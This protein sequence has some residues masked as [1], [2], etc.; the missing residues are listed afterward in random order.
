MRVAMSEVFI[1]H[2]IT[3]PSLTLNIDDLEKLKLI[4]EKTGSSPSFGIKTVAEELDFHDFNSFTKNNWPAN[5][6]EFTFRT[7]YTGRRIHG[8][9][10]TDNILGL[11]N[12]TIE[13]TDRDWISARV[14]ELKRFFDQHRN[15][16]NLFK[17]LNIV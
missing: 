17:I 6:N 3:I 5:I 4:L 15:W 1:T 14:D 16:H 11:S 2:K 9:I 12:V 7:N 10:Q 13:N 8:Y